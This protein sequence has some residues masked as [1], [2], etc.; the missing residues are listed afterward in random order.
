[1]GNFFAEIRQEFEKN[2]VL[3]IGSVTVLVYLLMKY[4][5]PLLLPFLLGGLLVTGLRYFLYKSCGKNKAGRSLLM[6]TILVLIA[7]I[8]GILLFVIYRAAANFLGICMDHIGELKEQC[9]V[10]LHTCCCYLGELSGLD[11]L[12][13]EARIIRTAE[14]IGEQIS[15]EAI[16]AALTLSSDVIAK[17]GYIGILWAVFFI[18]TILLAKDYQEIVA[19]FRRQ[20]YARRLVQIYD[21]TVRMILSYGKAQ[22]IIMSVIGGICSVGFWR[23]GYSMPFVWGYLVGFLDML[24]FIGT[25]ITLIPLAVFEL[26]LGKTGKAIL[27]VLLYLVCYFVRE[28]MEP[29]LIGRKIGIHPLIILISVFLGVRLYGL[30]GIITGPLSYLLIR[31]L[32]MERDEQKSLDK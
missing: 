31:E 18:F 9:I 8:P 15:D 3:R 22:I 20:T 10:I 23:M 5:L 30:L 1:M 12:V 21:K 27:L 28:F 7:G 24:P 2:Q 29:R 4:A 13:I 16:P 14:G 32:A 17:I 25:G 6:G 11:S 19:V 26:I